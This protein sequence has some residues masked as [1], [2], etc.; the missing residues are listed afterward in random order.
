MRV[1]REP[2]RERDLLGARKTRRVAARRDR[3]DPMDVGRVRGDRG[4]QGALPVDRESEN[5]RLIL[6]QERSYG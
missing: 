2:I 4:V 6:E 3:P 1:E 5:G